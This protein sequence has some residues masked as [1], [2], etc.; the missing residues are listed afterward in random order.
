M[1]KKL[2]KMPYAQARVEISE[3]GNRIYL[4]SYRTV[5]AHIINNWLIVNGL[6][7][8]TTRKHLG[9]FMQEYC[10]SN[11]AQAKDCYEKGYMLNIETGE[12]RF[13]KDVFNDK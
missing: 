10:K 3:D 1:T 9:A 7:S 2:S 5:V 6:Y 8:M 12:I 4:W 13:L 11:Y